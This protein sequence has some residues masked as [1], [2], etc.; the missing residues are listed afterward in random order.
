MCVFPD[1]SFGLCGLFSGT[2]SFGEDDPTETTLVSSGGWTAY[3]ARYKA[4][5][6]LVWAEVRKRL[7]H[8]NFSGWATAEVRGG[9][10]SRLTRMKAWMRDVL[11]L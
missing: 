11:D 3:A 9:D 8:V 6:E 4:D 7:A 2:T 10:E 5:G 1:G